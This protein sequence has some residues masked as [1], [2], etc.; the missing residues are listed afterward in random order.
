MRIRRTKRFNS[1]YK[2]L[3]PE[4]R[5]RT[6]KQIRLLLDDPHHPSLRVRK[7]KGRSNRWE[8]RVTIHYRLLF[9]MEGDT[10]VL[11]TIGTHD[12]LDRQ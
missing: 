3:P 7:L 5:E 6:K 4:I 1:L 12:V 8:L 11:H 9:E 2:K 10:Y